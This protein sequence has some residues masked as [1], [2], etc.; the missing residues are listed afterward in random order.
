MSRKLSPVAIA[1]D[2]DGTLAPGNMQEYDFIPALN[3]K[4]KEFWREVKKMAVDHEADEILAYMRL[5]L[6]KA[7]AAQLPVR[8]ADFKAFGASITLFPGVLQWF[9]RIDDYCFF[10]L[11]PV[12][13]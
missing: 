4:S 13:I 8:K 3:M 11:N 9:D 1:Y 5:M 2:F 10:I 6:S 12:P 7:Q